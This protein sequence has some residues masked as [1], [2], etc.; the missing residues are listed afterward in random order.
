MTAVSWIEKEFNKLEQLV[1]VYSVM[2]EIIEQAKELEKQQRIDDYNVGYNDAACNHIN[3][4][5]NYVNEQ[6]YL[7][8]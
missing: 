3:D 1:G 5:Y 6:D 2:Y 4:A 8:D 7:N